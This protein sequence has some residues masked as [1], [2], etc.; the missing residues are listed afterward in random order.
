MNHRIY[1]WINNIEV[2]TNVGKYFLLIKYDIIAVKAERNKLG[3]HREW[4]VQERQ[5]PTGY[6]PN[7]YIEEQR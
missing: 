7:H 3:I 4:L 1:C 5:V 6:K 2:G